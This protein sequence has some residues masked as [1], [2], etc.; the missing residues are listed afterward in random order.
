VVSQRN[1]GAGSR[2]YVLSRYPK[3]SETFVRNEIQG[4]RERGACI[5]VIS[6]ERGDS[7]NVDAGWAGDFRH[8]PRPS[9]RRAVL[10]HLWFGVRHPTS[11]VRYVL[12]LKRLREHWRFALQRLPTE[13]RRLLLGARAPEGCH[14]HFA[15]DT[16]SVACYLAR[17][18]DVPVSVTVHANDIYV[19]DERRLRRRLSH[20]DRVVTVCNFNVG[21]LSGLGITRV[22]D[23]GI[24]VVPCGVT[25]PEASPTLEPATVIDVVSVG[26]LVEKK[27]FDIFVRAVALVRD[28]FP[29]V[30]A[31]IVGD[32]PDRAALA[33]LIRELG[34]E[35]NVTLAGARRHEQ[36]LE[37]IER[38]KVFCL[39]SKRAKDG[40]CDAVPVAIREA[41]AR[42]IPVVS[43]HVAGIP[44][45][46]DDEVGWIV[47]PESPHQLAAAI[48]DALAN[49]PGR[50]ERGRAARERVL[51]RWTLDAQ[52][53]E[54]RRVFGR[55]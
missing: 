50:V 20:F 11:Y 52:V 27:G 23:G 55:S 10:D 30:N 15:W 41:M 38:A 34:L 19:G 22:G 25:V 45:T 24:H 46:V 53:E 33:A 37:L 39:A 3:L 32:G 6:L 26:R 14:T 18:L 49:E 1:T 9:T 28:R 17:L 21:L 43:T 54:M 2:L 44:E 51:R 35:H 13:A 8:L 36:T 40:D 7:A 47:D 31:M 42:A 12:A 16:A 4:L 5:D 48:S 29:N